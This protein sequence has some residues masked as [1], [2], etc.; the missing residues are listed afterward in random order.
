MK[1]PID[2]VSE[3]SIESCLKL[4]QCLNI[5]KTKFFAKYL[6]IVYANTL[7]LP[8][9]A[10]QSVVLCSPLSDNR[11]LCKWPQKSKF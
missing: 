7:K 9:I 1:C 5:K 3:R 6:F 8:G 2:D 11:F 4:L 10:L